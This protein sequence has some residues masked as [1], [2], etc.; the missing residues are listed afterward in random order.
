M[1]SPKNSIVVQV[2]SGTGRSSSDAPHPPNINKRPVKKWSRQRYPGALLFNLAS[3]VLPALYAT[4]SKLCVANI[5]TS[6]VATTDAYTYITV[7]AEVINEGLPRASWLII[8]NHTTLTLPQR[9]TLTH[10]FIL[11]QTLL[12]L[13]LSLTILAAAPRFAAAFV[14]APA[15]RRASIGY[16]RISS[17]S[18]LASA[19]EVAVATATRA[20]D[21]PDVPLLL[22]SAKFLLN[23][24]LDLLLL[25]PFRVCAR[26]Q[27]T[28][29]SPRRP[30]CAWPAT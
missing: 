23:I 10:T 18:C 15:S 20:L 13:L 14:P 11:T 26:H 16:V 21:R 9:L 25:S 5:S 8:G 12:G 6:L 17:F 7:V 22:S 27:R 24:A 3:F 19:I 29:A 30:A 2:G 28:P 1:P 4:L